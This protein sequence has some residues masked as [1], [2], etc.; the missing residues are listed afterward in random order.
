[1]AEP[2]GRTYDVR[3]WKTRTYKGRT[4]TTHSV[5]WRVQGLEHQK[6]FASAKLAESFR[7]GLVVAV[8]GGGPFDTRTGL[9]SDLTAPA[10]TVTWYRHAASFVD[11]KWAHASPKHRKSIAEGLMTAT[12]AAV[13]R[14][15]GAPEDETLR[16]AL[17]AWS[18]NTAARDGQPVG[19]A[20][21]P[22]AYEPALRWVDKNAVSLEEV[23]APVL[24]RLVLEALTLRLDG[25][26]ASPATV[27]RKRSVVYSALAYAVE[28]E[29]LATNPMDRVKLARPKHTD[30]VDRRV[31]VNPDQAAAL[32]AAVR[33]SYSSMEAFFACLNYAALRPAEARHLRE[34]DLVL[35]PQGWGSIN[36]L[37]STPTSGSAW[38]DT[39]KPDEDRQL[40]HRAVRDTRLVPAAPELVEI[41][42]R[43]LATFPSGPDGRLFVTRSGR[44]GVPIAPPYSRPQSMGVV[45]RVWA[46]ARRSVMGEDFV[47]SP[48]AR[49]PYDLRHAAVS[50]WLNTGVPATQVAEWAGHSVNVLLRVYAKCVY[51]QEEAAK[52]RI[53]AALT[54]GRTP[55]ERP[56]Q[57][58]IS[59]RILRSHPQSA[60]LGRPQSDTTGTDKKSL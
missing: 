2:T 60:G 10:G 20:V 18:F 36:L 9:P 32:L 25:T 7:S 21:P 53:E 31:V 58:E 16:H 57:P 40:K 8:N 33:D 59:P 23:A 35:P 43:H 48:L 1:M 34:R 3:G 26:P 28:L 42:H 56:T 24:L 4:R 54:A 55:H 27:A 47:D 6:T 15:A 30:V 13:R 51:G 46:N 52:L 38:T 5:R 44:A 12:M 50:L 39:G 14:T 19:K 37:G 49:R 11:R 17:L 29:R 45:Y 22:D 41:L